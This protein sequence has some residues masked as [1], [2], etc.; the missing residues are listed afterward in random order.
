V[1]FPSGLAGIHSQIPS[2]SGPPTSSRHHTRQPTAPPSPHLAS[3]RL[4]CKSPRLADKSRHFLPP[5]SRLC[6]VAG[7]LRYRCDVDVGPETLPTSFLGGVVSFARCIKEATPNFDEVFTQLAS[8]LG[9]NLQQYSQYCSCWGQTLVSPYTPNPTQFSDCYNQAL[10]ECGGKGN[11]AFG[12]ADR[13]ATHSAIDDGMFETVL[14]ALGLR[15]RPST[16]KILL[17]NLF[18][19][20]SADSAPPGFK[21]PYVK[22]TCGTPPPLKHT[23]LHARCLPSLLNLRL[24]GLSYRSGPS[25][26][27]TARSQHHPM[28]RSSALRPLCS[29]FALS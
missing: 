12:F 6:V 26:P 2:T 19:G 14:G 24:L 5:Q 9:L 20:G 4:T 7:G 16:A 15:G 25:L 22:P 3:P 21:C 18:T 11:A 17:K 1:P 27:C 10:G 8:P 13:N 29:C 23:I 28:P